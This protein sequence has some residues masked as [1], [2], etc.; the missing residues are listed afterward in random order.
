MSDS[1]FEFQFGSPEAY[2]SANLFEAAAFKNET[3][4][5]F[6]EFSRL[7][8]DFSK[9]DYKTA[10]GTNAYDQAKWL[11]DT[12]NEKKLMLA[13]ADLPGNEGVVSYGIYQITSSEQ[14]Q[15][16]TVLGIVLPKNFASLSKDIM[17]L[18]LGKM[19]E[20]LKSWQE[21]H[22]DSL[23]TTGG[24]DFSKKAT[25]NP[26]ETGQL[27]PLLQEAPEDFFVFDPDTGAPI[28]TLSPERIQELREIKKKPTLL[29]LIMW[30]IVRLR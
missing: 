17:A 25:W 27:K 20:S 15:P 2:Q 6:G 10:D 19:I 14:N 3:G 1:N 12:L 28:E 8:S 21:Q 4:K 29:N 18:Q 26:V 11:A 24:V 16:A 23:S 5:V 7:V 13:I 9:M 30:I 22:Q